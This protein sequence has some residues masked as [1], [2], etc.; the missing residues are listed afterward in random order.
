MITAGMVA[1]SDLYCR[2]RSTKLNY[3]FFITRPTSTNS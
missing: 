1:D 3:L 2:N